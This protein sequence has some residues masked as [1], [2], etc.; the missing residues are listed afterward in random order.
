[1]T[2]AEAKEKAIENFK[3]GMN[4]AQAVSEVFAKEFGVDSDLIKNI[5]LPFGAGMCRIR[6]VCGTV[7]GM[8]FALGMY[9]NQNKQKTEDQKAA[10]D[11]T[12]TKGQELINKFTELNGSIICRELLGLVPIGTSE[13]MLKQGQP[14][15]HT[16]DSPISEKR[17]E[18]YY[19]KRPCAELCGI[20]AE[21]FQTWLNNQ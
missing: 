16:P 20:A 13:A 14:T 4:C 8:L 9:Q 12:Y 11:N 1:M 10:K 17:T 7:S 3:S 18:E 2:P 15:A 19:K 5:S 21:I 6:E